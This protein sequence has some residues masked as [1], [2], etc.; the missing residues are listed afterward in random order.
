MT[1]QV[2]VPSPRVLVRDTGFFTVPHELKEEL[3][4]CTL[5]AIPTRAIRARVNP[6]E[7]DHAQAYRLEV[8]PEGPLV[9][10]AGE[11]GLY[12]GLMT[13]RQLVR[14]ADRA[15]RIPCLRI[16]DR[17]DFSV[18]GVMLDISR[19][20]VP[21]M[22][23]LKNL[24]DL[25]SELKFNQ[26]QLYTEHTF[27]Y[28]A[29]RI[30]WENASPLTPE[31]VEELDLYCAHRAIEL[32]PN[33]NSFG[34]MER[35]LKHE[36]YSHLAE[37]TG[38]FVDPWG[39]IRH[40]PT[41]LNPL[42]TGSIELLSSL[43]DELLPHFTSSMVNVGADEPFEL[44][45][46]R[47]KGICLQRGLGRVYLDFILNVHREISRRGKT[48]LFFGDIVLHHSELIE[49][50]PRDVIALDWGYEAAHPF[51]RESRVFAG[52]GVRFY[53]CPGTSA[54]NSLGGRWNNARQ[55]ILNAAREGLASGASGLLLTDWGD[56]GHWQQLPV[57]Y[58]GY[59]LAAE[60]AWN[61]SGAAG[62]DMEAAL[63]RH[64]FGAGSGNA[65]KALITLGNLYDDGIAVLRNA[66][67]LAVLLLPDLQQ[68]HED[69]LKNFEGYD[70]SRELNAI[71]A[72]HSLLDKADLRARDA[73]LLI[74]ELRFTADL[75]AH[76][77]RLGKERFSSRDLR[78]NAIPAS[79]LKTLAEELD[80]LI[81]RFEEL[82]LKRSRPGGLE[83]SKGRL[84][85]LMDSY[86][87]G[88]S[89]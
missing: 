36:P 16:E 34:H 6:G 77:A 83:D 67:I 10:A 29:H 75:M 51:D 61:Q 88:Q 42:D 12:Y 30:V 41:T 35:W 45:Q 25:W 18:R 74:E 46:G 8:A 57:S 55:N 39:G 37:A 82:W 22:A 43:Y 53:V 85:T 20:R 59:L 65:A 47:S 1:K 33:Q 27:A 72:A 15:G 79:V 26:V 50:L 5:G 86:R 13:L 48:M 44:G 3:D 84:Q 64:V 70:F 2:L 58:P 66:G 56:N 80:P 11:R 52:A 23:T 17:P 73:P 4:T 60:A 19:D 62:M 31:E 7:V 89:F 78:M 14:Q 68:Y 76:A 87:S 40:H 81:Q 21:T 38:S 54:W 28:P 69:H 63:S 49:R 24:I 32:V 71:A 9:T